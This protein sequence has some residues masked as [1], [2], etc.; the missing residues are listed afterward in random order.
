MNKIKIDKLESKDIRIKEM[1]TTYSATAY[2]D[3]S[4]KINAKNYYLAIGAN[5]KDKREI[6]KALSQFFPEMN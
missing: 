4:I 1:I 2:Y 5:D 6:I 3:I